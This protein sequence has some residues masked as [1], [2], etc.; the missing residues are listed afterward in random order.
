MGLIY[1]FLVE[2]TGKWPYVLNMQGRCPEA[3]M[4]NDYD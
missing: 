1:G 3:P 4:P 2:D